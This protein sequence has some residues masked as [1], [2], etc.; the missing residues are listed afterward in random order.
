[1][2]KVIIF[3]KALKIFFIV[4]DLNG[5]K[6]LRRENTVKNIKKIFKDNFHHAWLALLNK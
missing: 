4:H 5:G 2:Y 6:F 3:F 1:M